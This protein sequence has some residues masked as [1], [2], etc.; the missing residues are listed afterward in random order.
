MVDFLICFQCLHVKVFIDGKNIGEFPISSEK[1][2]MINLI[3]DRNKIMRPG[4]PNE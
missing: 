3:L 4:K 1:Q 2:Q